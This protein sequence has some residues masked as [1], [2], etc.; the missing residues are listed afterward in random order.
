MAF[1]RKF[2]TVSGARIEY[3]IGGSG[4]PMVWLHGSEGNLGWLRVHDDL[5]R[6]FT[7]YVP[8]HPG[9]AGSQR[10]SWLESFVDLSRLYLWIFQELGLSKAILAGHFI[11]GWLAAE[12]AVMS[13]QIVERLLLI[14]A[15]GVRPHKGEIL[16]IFLHGSEATRRLSF[17][18]VKEV[19]DYD[20][21]FGSKPTPE[22][23]EVHVINREAATRYCWKPYMHDPA[24]PPLLWRLRNIPTLVIWG[25][26]DRIVPLECGELYRNAVHGAQLAVIDRCGHFPHLEKPGEFGRA[27][28]PFLA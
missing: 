28:S 21:L 9:F 13:P 15:A 18:D 14:D 7:V 5:A 2:V 1:E 4:A 12:M 25:R 24:L 10:P 6:S 19:C 26:E 22:T 17:F 11:G 3:F 8:T 27:L 23:R 16:D 20:L